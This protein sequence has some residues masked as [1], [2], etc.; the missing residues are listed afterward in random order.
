MRQARELKLEQ[1]R[2]RLAK[3]KEL[4]AARAAVQWPARVAAFRASLKAG[5]RFKWT[6]P[7]SGVWGGPVV[8]MVVRVDTAM[9]L[10]QFDNLTIGG[11]PTRY[12]LREQLEP[13][14]GP[15]PAGRYEI[16]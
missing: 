1:E 7:P 9:A 16:K 12:V 8:G 5:D 6:S 2:Q 11:Q 4:D 13:F 3:E 14:D 10:V 15:A